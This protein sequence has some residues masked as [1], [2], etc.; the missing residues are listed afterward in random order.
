MRLPKRIAKAPKRASRC[1][2]Y[3]DEPLIRKPHEEDRDWNRRCFCD[4]LCSLRS[5]SPY[6]SRSEKLLQNCAS[7]DANGCWNWTEHK[8]KKG[9]GRTTDASGE[10]LAHRLSYMEF[11]GPIP[12]G[13]HILHSCDNP[14][15][16][17]PDH[18]RPGTNAENHADK[19]LRGRQAR[20]AGEENPRAKLTASDVVVIRTTVGTNKSLAKTYGVTESNISAI[21]CGRTWR[22]V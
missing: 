1:C 12:Q 5:R 19:M 20:L 21:R 9:Y 22:G 15:C 7:A 8:D 10:V 6:V 16:I 4:R 11:I 17:N 14:S 18:L 2:E 3:C 13:M